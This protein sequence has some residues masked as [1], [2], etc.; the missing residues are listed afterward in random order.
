MNRFSFRSLCLAGVAACLLGL[1]TALVLQYGFGLDPCPLCIFQRIAMFGCGLGFLGGALF[2]PTRPRGRWLW[3]GLAALGALAGI[4]VAG[5]HVWLQHL[6]PD[7]VPACGP[8]L[9]YLLG[10]LP[11]S[12]VIALVLQGDGNCAKVDAALLGLSL[13]MWTLLAFIALLLYAVLLP[14]QARRHSIFA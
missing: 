5:R 2:A 3:S 1:A 4:G 10:M 8:T 12:E 9:D 14:L 13:P 11:V 6:P 7:Q